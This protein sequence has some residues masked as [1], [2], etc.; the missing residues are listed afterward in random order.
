MSTVDIISVFAKAIGEL[1]AAIATMLGRDIEE[2][3]TELLA[4]PE[5]TGR[6]SDAVLEVIKANL[7]EED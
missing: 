2:V 5:V 1:I 6:A 4:H 7:P 3:R